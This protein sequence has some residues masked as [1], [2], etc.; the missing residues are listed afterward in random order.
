MKEQFAQDTTEVTCKIEDEIV[1]YDGVSSTYDGVS[2]TYEQGLRYY[3]GWT[4]SGEGVIYS[5]D[6]VAQ[7]PAYSTSL[8]FW[9]K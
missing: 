6:G 7:D 5:V 8:H 9:R 2:S 1:P 3:L 4:Y